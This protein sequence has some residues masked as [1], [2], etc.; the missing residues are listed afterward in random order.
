MTTVRRDELSSF[1]R[2]RRERITPE[3]VG[4]PPGARRKTPGLRR[5]EVA[6]LAGVGVTWYT[7]LEQGRAINASAQV[8]GAVARTLRLDAAER[9]HLYRLAE[10]SQPPVGADPTAEALDHLEPILQALDPLPAMVL[11]ARGDILRWNRTCEVLHPDLIGTVPEERNNLWYLFTQPQ[12]RT[13]IVNLEEQ[14]AEVVAVF[15]YRYSHHLND[16]RWLDFVA[17]L[18]AASPLFARYWDF[19]DVASPRPC[20]KRYDFPRFGE[21]NFRST[22]MDLTDHPGLRVVVHTPVDESSRRRVDQILEQATTD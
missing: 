19:H 22:S 9:D 13:H 12:E 4:M 16:P 5:E 7:W 10:V 21:V 17:R 2:S 6:Q 11:N 14:A 15:R 1:L 18:C 3:D 20:Q 8:L